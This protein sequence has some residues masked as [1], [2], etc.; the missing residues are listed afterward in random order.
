MGSFASRVGTDNNDRE[1]SI[2]RL[3]KVDGIA[4]KTAE[5]MYDI[6]IHTCEDLARYLHHHTAEEVSRWPSRN[7]A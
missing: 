1:N 2:N 5:A 6:G 3:A 4:R 7:T